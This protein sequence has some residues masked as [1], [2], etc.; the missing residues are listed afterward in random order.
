MIKNLCVLL[1]DLGSIPSTHIQ[2]ITVYSSNSWESD[3]GNSGPLQA[4]GTHMVI[5]IHP[6]RENSF[7]FNLDLFM[8]MCTRP[9]CVYVVVPKEMRKRK[10]TLD[11]QLCVDSCAPRRYWE[12][13]RVAVGIRIAP[14][15]SNIWLIVTREWHCLKGLERLRGVTLLEEVGHWDRLWS[16]KSP[17]HGRSHP[18]SAC[19]PAVAQ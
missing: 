4:P 5:H 7:V 15:G 2:F 18:I 16:F 3:S 10:Q 14:I 11:L 1:E 19:S 8:C 6:H 13:S 9:A 17:S 12:G